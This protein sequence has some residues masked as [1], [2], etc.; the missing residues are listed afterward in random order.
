MTGEFPMQMEIKKDDACPFLEKNDCT[1]YDSRPVSCQAFPLGFN[2]KN[3]IL[4]T[5]DC[6][7]VGKGKMTKE[8]LE[9]IRI[10]ADAGYHAKVRT[11]AILPALQAIILKEAMNKSEEAVSKLSSEDKEKLKT[12]FEEKK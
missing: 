11:I 5:E 12:I 9:E 3:F 1:I 2:G 8:S 6:Q 4:T 7:G 10:S